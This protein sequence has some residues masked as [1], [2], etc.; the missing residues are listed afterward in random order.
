MADDEV[1]G[2]R[3]IDIIEAEGEPRPREELIRQ[4]RLLDC[5]RE[6]IE[7]AHGPAYWSMI[8]RAADRL[9][10][11]RADKLQRGVSAWE[12]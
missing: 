1:P 10:S 12:T 3:I 9:R 5:V 2:L 4:V 8:Y 7:R 6:V 11:E